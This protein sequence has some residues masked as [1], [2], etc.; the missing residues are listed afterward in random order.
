MQI[1]FELLVGHLWLSV[2]SPIPYWGQVFIWGQASERHHEGNV[3]EEHWEGTSRRKR[4]WSHPRKMS[5]S[6]Q[7]YK[8]LDLRNSPQSKGAFNH[9]IKW[10]LSMDNLE[11]KMTVFVFQKIS[12]LRL[13]Q[14]CSLGKTQ[15]SPMVS[16]CSLHRLQITFADK[17]NGHG[18]KV[19]VGECDS[20]WLL[21]YSHYSCSGHQASVDWKAKWYKCSLISERHEV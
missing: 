2:K 8:A 19:I 18:P 11:I 7:F 9:C 10:H 17:S 4:N 15:D 1:C 3:P 13:R 21:P 12:E 6:P 5:P 20:S 14:N 16:E